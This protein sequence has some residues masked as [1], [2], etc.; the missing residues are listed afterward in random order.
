VQL[1]YTL[2]GG[3]AGLDY[4]RDFASGGVI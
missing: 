1:I 4:L 2:H 3:E